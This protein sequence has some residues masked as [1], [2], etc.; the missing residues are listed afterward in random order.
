MIDCII[1]KTRLGSPSI[2]WTPDNIATVKEM[3]T[4]IPQKSV[5]AGACESGLTYYEAETILRKYICLKPGK[6]HYMQWLFP[7]DC[8][9][10]MKLTE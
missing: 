3:F 8:D 6:S 7:E 10:R 5:N 4:G 1:D 9:I 2:S